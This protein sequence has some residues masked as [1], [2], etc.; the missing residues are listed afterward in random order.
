L[1]VSSSSLKKWKQEMN[2]IL[3]IHELNRKKT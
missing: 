3:T 2:L 1:N